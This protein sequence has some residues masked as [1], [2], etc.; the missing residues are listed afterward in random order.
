MA[1]Q[2]VPGTVWATHGAWHWRVK[3]PDEDKRRDIVLT[4]PF[5]GKRIP[6]DCDQSIAESAAF[7]LW[8]Q[9]VKRIRPDGSA[10]FTVN[11][12]CDRWVVHA[13]EYY[14]HPDGTPTGRSEIAGIHV[15][16]LRRLYG[17]RPVEALTHPDMLAL[18]KALVERGLARTTI[19]GCLGSVRRLFTWALDE[20]LISAQT[21]AELTQ[22]A[23]LAP[24]RSA[25]RETKPITSVPDDVIEATCAHLP[26]SLAD[27]VRLHRLTGMRPAEACAISWERIERVGDVWA[28]RPAHH[29]NEWRRQARVVALGPRAQEI[30]RRY[31]GA[32]GCIFSPERAIA[33]R[34]DRARAE[35]VSEVRDGEDARRERARREAG[36]AQRTYSEM[37][38]VH[39]YARAIARACDTHGIAHWSPNQLRHTCA[40]VVRR[41]FGLAAA[42]AVLG[43][44]MGMR[45]TDRYSFE[46][47]EDELLREATPAMLALG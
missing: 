19:N 32:P 5:S 11:E 47:A 17:Q 1:K 38:D 33:E 15:R 21:K 31:E 6:A 12:L 37:W 4:F 22:V 27:L 13:E 40:T 9:R 24:F 36:M 7:R 29:K 3:F 26:P 23:N 46:A 25:A 16:E 10:I 39:A 34:Y 18:R 14:R 43:H 28:Y 8:D 41:R 2:Q 45:I 35:R 42:R 44:S 30:L 20:A